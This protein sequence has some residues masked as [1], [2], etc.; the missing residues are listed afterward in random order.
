MLIKKKDSIEKHNSDSCTVHEYES[1]SKSMS[2]ATA[3]I[4]GFYPNKGFACNTGCEEIYYVISGTGIIYTDKG[5]SKVSEGDM[6]HFEK[7]EKY[8]VEGKKLFLALIN[9]PPWNIGQY[10]IFTK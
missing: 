3:M 10:K 7:G 5:A 6:Y 9:S 4:D 2:F 8:R 1:G